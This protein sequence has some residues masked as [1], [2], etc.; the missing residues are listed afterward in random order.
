[1]IDNFK[2]II[3]KRR[4]YYSISNSSNVSDHD[5]QEIMEFALKYL[6]SAFHSQTSRL[7]LL[8]GN[9]HKKFWE[10]VKETL[11]GKMGG[12][13]FSKTEEKLERS[14]ASG[15]GT[16]LFYEDE[17]VIKELQEK[18]PLYKDNFPVWAEHTSAMHQLTIWSML[19]EAGFGAS[20]QHYNPIIDDEVRETWDLP[21]D[22]K[23]IAQMPFGVPVEPPG[24]KDFL[25][26]ESRI[27]IFKS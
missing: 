9:D 2:K 18:N 25:P 5:I 24:E 10:I 19:V 15:Y 26:L 13:D 11:R 21:G 7:V 8:L 20:L 22:W 27:K 16:I 4:S 1:M 12:R 17:V 14:F 3:E 23:L 6:P